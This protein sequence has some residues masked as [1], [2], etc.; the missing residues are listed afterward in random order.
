[1]VDL[2]LFESVAVAPLPRAHFDR[3]IELGEL[4][5]Q[6]VE[7]LYGIMVEMP[8]QGAEHSDVT[9]LL[10]GRLLRLLGD[11]AIVRQHGPL[12]LGA[13]SEPEPD[14]AVVP[15]GQYRRALPTAASLIVEVARSSLAKDR[16]VKAHLYA[17]SEIPEYWII[18]LVTESVEVRT[19][20]QGPAYAR[21]VTVDRA[22][23]IRLQRFPD[24]Q[25]RISDLFP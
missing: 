10:G 8:P 18:D 2:G 21:V 5:D 1:M 16:G 20:P 4:D 3:L 6:R 7:L 9:A 14:I 19:E 11:H 25:I 23:A 13:D 24:V 22:G 15:P 12:A 17:E